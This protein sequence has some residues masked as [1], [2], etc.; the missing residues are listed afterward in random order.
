MLQ[1]VGQ[2][3][4]AVLFLQCAHIVGNVKLRAS[5]GVLIM[6]DIVCESVAQAAGTEFRPGGNG[7]GASDGKNGQCGQKQEDTFHGG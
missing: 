1:E 6:A 5:G 2:A 3:V 7:L 4:L